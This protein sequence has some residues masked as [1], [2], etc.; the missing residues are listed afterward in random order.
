[1]DAHIREMRAFGVRVLFDDF[2]VGFSSFHDLQESDMDGLKLDKYLVE[3][4]STPQ[5][6]SILNAMVQ[7]GHELGLTILAEGV[8]QAAQAQVLQQL[9]CDV[10]QGFYF[11]R[12]MP[13]EQSAQKIIKQFRTSTGHSET[14][15]RG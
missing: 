4:I 12:P 7:A 3:N 8:E 10:L 13:A 15:A 9:G 2:G 11:S 5:G 14:D 6:R 1:M